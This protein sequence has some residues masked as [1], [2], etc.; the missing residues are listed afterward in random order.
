VES[1]ERFQQ[2]LHVTGMNPDVILS[3][4]GLAEATLVV[5]MP[6]PGE[7][8]IWYEFDGQRIISV[9]RLLDDTNVQVNPLNRGELSTLSE[10]QI[11]VS[12]PSVIKSYWGEAID[13]AGSIDT[14]DLGF[15]HDGNLFITG[16]E[17]DLIIHSGVNLHP[18]WIEKAVISLSGF[19]SGPTVLATCAYSYM[20]SSIQ[21]EKIG[22]VVE[23]RGRCNNKAFSSFVK[24]RI[25]EAFS[26]P[27]DFVHVCK[28]GTIP[29]TTSGKIQRQMC[30]ELF[31]D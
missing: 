2:A 1:V 19:Q 14:G 20:D 22:V 6:T 8:I 9:G 28:P 3:G 18:H 4:Y 15:F 25:L 12:G 23:L 30:A 13:N 31:S 10:G 29:R 7:K 21:R 26:V 11:I 17:K 27:I 5:S 16:R 24:K